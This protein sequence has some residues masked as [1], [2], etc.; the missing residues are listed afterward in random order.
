MNPP[1]PKGHFRVIRRRTFHMGNHNPVSARYTN[2]ATG[3]TCTMA[4]D[5]PGLFELMWKSTAG[6]VL[7][8]TGFLITHC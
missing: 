2:T 6:P 7:L 8:M 1:S 4:L 3:N 5:N